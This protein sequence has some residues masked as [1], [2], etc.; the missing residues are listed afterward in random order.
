[1]LFVV[2]ILGCWDA[3]EQKA[4]I[5]DHPVILEEPMLAE[6]LILHISNPKELSALQSQLSLELNGT[7]SLDLGIPCTDRLSWPRR[8]VCLRQPLGK[9]SSST[10]PSDPRVGISNDSVSHKFYKLF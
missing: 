4:K 8:L 3:S 5:E 7:T 1:M 2:M 6:D 9:Y 10:R